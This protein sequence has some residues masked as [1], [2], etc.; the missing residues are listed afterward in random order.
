MLILSSTRA[1][2]ACGRGATRLHW[3]A[4]IGFSMACFT[5]ACDGDDPARQMALGGNIPTGNLATIPD[6]SV[7]DLPGDGL[8]P[9]PESDTDTRQREPIGPERLNDE[10]DSIQDGLG[11]SGGQSSSA[12]DAAT[13]SADAGTD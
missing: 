3:A 10:I 1:R 2:P 13:D 7:R 8:E 11:G 6:A 9:T 4:L 5:V 12:P